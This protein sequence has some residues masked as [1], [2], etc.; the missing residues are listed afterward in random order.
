[1]HS[2]KFRQ[3]MSICGIDRDRRAGGIQI[4]RLKLI[5]TPYLQPISEMPDSDY[6]AEGFAYLNENKHLV[7][8]CMPYDVSW[9]GFEAWRRSGA[10]PYVIEFKIEEVFPIAIVMLDELKE[11]A[12]YWEYVSP[13]E[14]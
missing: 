4:L 8:T 2:K 7:P 3:D 11:S 13:G 5:K 9:E 10:T 6:E 1:M 14:L 12:H